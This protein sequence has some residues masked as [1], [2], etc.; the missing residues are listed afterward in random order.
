[1]KLCAGVFQIPLREVTK[2]PYESFSNQRHFPLTAPIS[3]LE[4][5]PIRANSEVWGAPQTAELHE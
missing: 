1:M 3:I 5:F 4:R 2:S